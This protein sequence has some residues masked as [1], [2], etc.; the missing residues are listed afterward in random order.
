MFAPLR[1]I[2]A[3]TVLLALVLCTPQGSLLLCASEG[4]HV[5]LEAACSPVSTAAHDEGHA[6]QV[7]DHCDCAGDCGPCTDARLGAEWA[8]GR[9]RDDSAGM[10]GSPLPTPMFVALAAFLTGPGS[11]CAPHAPAIS[12]SAGR[13]SP[14][15]TGTCLRI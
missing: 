6:A 3:A 12:S 5:S 8:A 15:Q 14:V 7:A 4:G 1:R 10:S 11:V 13:S 9:V 2:A